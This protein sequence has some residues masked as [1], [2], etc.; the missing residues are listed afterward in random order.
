M[1]RADIRGRK[2]PPANPPHFKK[3]EG[4]QL[5]ERPQ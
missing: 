5:A 1:Q 2:A 4:F 3:P